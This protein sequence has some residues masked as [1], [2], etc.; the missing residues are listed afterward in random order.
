MEKAASAMCTVFERDAGK[1]DA[2]GSRRMAK[3]IEKTSSPVVPAKVWFSLLLMYSV[4]FF[5]CVPLLLFMPTA[6]ATATCLQENTARPRRVYALTDV[7]NAFRGNLSL[8]GDHAK[9]VRRPH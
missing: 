3:L 1:A 6:C 4:R 2:A 7:T 5:G 8:H 9:Q